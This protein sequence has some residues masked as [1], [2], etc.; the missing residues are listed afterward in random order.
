MTRHDAEFESSTAGAA[1][2]GADADQLSEILSAACDIWLSITPSGEIRALGVNPETKSLGCL[3]HWTGRDLREFLTEESVPKFEAR[4]SATLAEG[5]VKVGK[6]KGSAEKGKKGAQTRRASPPAVAP[7]QTVELNHV[8]NANW[9]FPIRYVFRRSGVTDEVLLLGRDLRP[10]AEVQQQLVRAQLSLEKD[11]EKHRGYETRFRVLLERTRDS[12]VLVAPGGR[13]IT[14]N[15]SAAQLLGGDVTGLSGS[16][17]SQAFEDQPRAA[18]LETLRRC[19]ASDND[20]SVA[21]RT[22]RSRRPTHVYP[23]IFRS[24]GEVLLLCR[25]DAADKARPASEEVRDHLHELFLTG[26][27]AIVFTDA[28]GVIR[29]MNEAFLALGDLPLASDAKD[30]PLSEF[31]ARGDVDLKVLL[32]NAARHGKMRLYSTKVKSAFGAE[33]A[34]EIS[35]VHFGER[36][37]PVCAF[38]IRDASRS[39]AA[40]DI[41]VGDDAARNVME[42]VGSAPLRELVAATT[43]VVE[44]LCIETAIDLTRNNRVAAA[45]M[46]GLSRQSLYVKLRKYGLFNKNDDGD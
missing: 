8:D 26:V 1:S 11:Y 9:E 12:F 2:K 36:A 24:A 33:T 45:E 38:V 13:I 32:D 16:A 31:L 22:R 28:R 27:E 44:K 23:T 7:R 5:D 29:H 3:D 25:I 43:D 18:F 34:V 40:R 19:A 37:E 30:K 4:L 35:A 42:L 21:A 17:F 41:G 6:S 46:L 14:L 15:A 20:Q 39:D 10:I